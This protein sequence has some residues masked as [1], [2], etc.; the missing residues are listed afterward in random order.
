MPKRTDIKKILIIGSGPIII[1][2]ACEFDYS[3]TQACKALK[4]EGYEVI[5]V[6]SNP[7]TIMTD[8]ETADGPTSSRSPPRRWRRSSPRSG[9]TPCC[10][11]WAARPGLNTAV[12][13]AEAG[14]LDKYGVEMIGASLP[15]IHK[16]EDRQLFREAMERIGLKV[17]KSGFARS[18]EEVMAVA[19]EIGFPIII[20]PSFTLGGTGSGV[21]YN[22][23]ELAE[24]AKGGLDASMI[25]EI[26]LEQSALGWKEFELEVMRDKADN[27][28]IICSIENVDPMGVHTGESITVAPSQTL[29]DVEYQKMRDAAI[30][31]MREIGVET[32]GSNVQFAIHPETGEMIVIEMN[33]RVS[34]S[35]ALASKATGFP[36][37]K[38]A[39]KLAVGYTLDEI[40]NDITRETMASFEPTIDYCV[41]KI[42]RWTFE[43]FP[44]TE[45]VLTTSMK[46]V[47]ETMAIGRTFREALQ[48]AIRSLEIKR[49]GLMTELPGGR[50]QPPGVPGAEAQDPQFAPPL[51]HRRGVQ[52]RDD[53]RG[54]P[55]PDDDRSLVP[56]PDPDARRGGGGAQEH[57]PRRRKTSGRRSGWASP[58]AISAASG[59]SPRRRSAAAATTPGSSPSTSSS[60]PA[61]RSSR[62]TPPTTTPPTRPRTRRAP[63]QSRRS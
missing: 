44:E 51:L 41:V 12:A 6:N 14:V 61:P 7:A 17:P 53:D 45:D 2:Q 21:A 8:P 58:T 4:E 33:P 47:G 29:T 1:S 62:P 27:V 11:R 23:E 16:A 19:A 48:K 18:M 39:A 36:I 60:T 35:S 34:R 5:L 20:R 22:R 37:A 63:R 56:P 10:P 3:G 52:S 9:P 40:P 43:K 42:P 57:C 38:I 26:M 24:I 55:L 59:T 49:F 32:G 31:I 30:A 50:P 54:D 25:H 13:V 28:V 15:V 46:S